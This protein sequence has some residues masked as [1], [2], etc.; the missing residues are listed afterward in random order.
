MTTCFIQTDDDSALCVCDN[1]QHECRA[2][3]LEM[4]SDIQ[5]R[6]TPGCIVP[7]GQCRECGALS[8]LKDTPA[9]TAQ[10]KLEKREAASTATIMHAADALLKEIAGARGLKIDASGILDPMHPICI[11]ADNLATALKSVPE[12][13]P[14]LVVVLEGGVVQDI[15]SSDPS[16]FGRVFVL[17]YDTEGSAL[18]DLKMIPQEDGSESKAH[19]S[20]FGVSEATIG[21]D[22]AIRR[23]DAGETLATGMTGRLPDDTEEEEHSLRSKGWIIDFDSFWT[24][25]RKADEPEVTDD[26]VGLC[27]HEHGE[28]RIFIRSAK[29]AMEYDAECAARKNG[30]T[31]DGDNGGVIYNTKHYESWK[32][33]V[34]WAGTGGPNDNGPIYD[35]WIECCEAEDIAH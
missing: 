30:W 25:V 32:A 23:H 4:V 18:A 22:E 8:Y 7:A 20:E 2:D 3:E 17:D 15:V 5:E 14:P 35:S 31:R 12:P 16:A 6:I 34:S 24:R 33:A 1:C 9:Y 21:L 28:D 10:A 19:F 29:L 26:C 11:M 27:A 13:K